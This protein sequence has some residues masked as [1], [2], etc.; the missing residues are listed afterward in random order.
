VTHP[1]RFRGLTHWQKIGALF[2]VCLCIA[3]IV[4]FIL[5]VGIGISSEID[6]ACFHGC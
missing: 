2:A 4:S 5:W 6:R 3:G 1:P